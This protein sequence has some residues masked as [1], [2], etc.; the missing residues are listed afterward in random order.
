MNKTAFADAAKSIGAPLFDAQL[1]EFERFEDALY[2]A[3]QV[4]NLTS[5]PKNEAWNRHFLDSLLLVSMLPQGSA[6]VDLGTGP[7]L[8]AWC[9]ACARRDLRLTGVDSNGKMLGFL[10]DHPLPNLNVLQ[11]RVEDWKVRNKFDVV[12]GRA[13][14]PLTI[15]LESSASL[16][17]IGGLVIPMRTPADGDSVREFDPTRLGLELTAERLVPLPGTDVVRLFPIYTKVRPTPAIYP[18]RWAEMK[19][20]PLT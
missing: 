13:F 18:R 3:N 1:D 20:K 2:E 19:A 17:K 4:M 14:A 6:V 9:L 15:Q 5:V 7:G 11:I 12:T 8:P 10:R 16:C